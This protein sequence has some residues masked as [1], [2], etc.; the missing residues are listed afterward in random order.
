MAKI[1]IK[2]EKDGLRGGLF[3][4]LLVL[5]LFF[6]ACGVQPTTFFVLRLEVPVV[7]SR[8]DDGAISAAR[9]TLRTCCVLRF[10]F[11]VVAPHIRS[12]Y[13]DERDAIG[14][15]ASYYITN[16][17]PTEYQYCFNLGL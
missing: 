15:M 6:G 2:S 13:H 4:K 11:Y 1:H 7:A 8:R 14:T 3:S 17:Q 9:V 5:C 12:Y 16:M 10:A